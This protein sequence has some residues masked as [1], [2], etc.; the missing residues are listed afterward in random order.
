MQSDSDL[1]SIRNSCDVWSIKRVYFLKKAEVLNFELFFWVGNE[2]PF[3]LHYVTWAMPERKHFFRDPSL[4]IDINWI[5]DGFTNNLT[6]VQDII[7]R[8]DRA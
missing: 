8:S 2:V 5:M 3:L 7:K 6:M 4:T 1:D